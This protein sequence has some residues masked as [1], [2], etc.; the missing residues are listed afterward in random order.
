ME[1]K[2]GNYA[3]EWEQKNK[4]QWPN[5]YFLM[6]WGVGLWWQHLL[7]MYKLYTVAMPSFH[8]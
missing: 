6:F 5:D 8:S 1:E 2:F 7:F 4:T 3:A